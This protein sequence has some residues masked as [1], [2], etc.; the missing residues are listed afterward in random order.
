MTLFRMRSSPSPAGGR[1]GAGRTPW[2][3]LPCWYPSPRRSLP[4]AAPRA[5]RGRTRLW[6]ANAAANTV[7][8]L[9]PGW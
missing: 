8:E 9:P 4:Q 7:T 2:R 6:V 3:A 1:A 5:G